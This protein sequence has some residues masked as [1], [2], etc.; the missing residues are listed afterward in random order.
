MKS[1][2]EKHEAKENP[3]RSQVLVCSWV[4]GGTWGCKQSPTTPEEQLSR[5]ST[6]LTGQ[7]KENTALRFAALT[8]ANKG[9]QL[10]PFR[11]HRPEFSSWMEKQKIKVW[12]W[13]TIYPLISS[14]RDLEILDCPWQLK[15]NCNG[16]ERSRLPTVRPSAWLWWT[17]C[18]KGNVHFVFPSPM[19][20][21]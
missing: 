20:R 8:N 21:M 7:R 3:C 15:M 17:G 19:S 18:T 4:L 13:Q 16:Q 11:K 5:C 12:I 9:W 10:V 1:A 6:S 2:I 14:V